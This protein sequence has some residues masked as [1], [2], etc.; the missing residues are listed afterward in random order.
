MRL[1]VFHVK[2]VHEAILAA[3]SRACSTGSLPAWPIGRR[4]PR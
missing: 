2:L 3:L 4:I 1:T